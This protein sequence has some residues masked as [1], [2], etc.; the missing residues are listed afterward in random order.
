M[1][2]N[3][4]YIT[5]GLFLFCALFFRQSFCQNIKPADV[6]DIK[7][8]VNYQSYR[9]KGIITADIILNI[10]DGWHI[11]ANKTFDDFLTPTTIQ[12]KDSSQVKIISISY[13]PPEIKKLSF[14]DSPLALYEDHVIIKFVFKVDMKKIKKNFTVDG[15]VSYQPCNNKTCLFPVV[16]PFAIKIK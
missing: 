5:A 4:K 7:T 11:N 3:S 14:S 10:K 6:V 13:P 12:L 8:T 1:M 15:E 9:T 16:K 2:L